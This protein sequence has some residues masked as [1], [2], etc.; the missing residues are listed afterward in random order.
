MGERENED[1]ARDRVKVRATR[2]ARARVGD[3][4]GILAIYRR[5]ID[6]ME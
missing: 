2:L 4:D 1:L 3:V 5:E 6:E